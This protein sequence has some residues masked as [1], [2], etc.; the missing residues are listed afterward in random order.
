MLNEAE[1]FKTEKNKNAVLNLLI[2]EFE[3]PDFSKKEIQATFKSCLK[4]SPLYNRI[5]DK[6][7]HKLFPNLYRKTVELQ[8]CASNGEIIKKE[9]TLQVSEKSEEL[10]KLL[11]D[12]VAKFELFDFLLFEFRKNTDLELVIIKNSKTDIRLALKEKDKPF[13]YVQESSS[14]IDFNNYVFN[15]FV[16]F[17][18][19]MNIDQDLKYVYIDLLE[20]MFKR[21]NFLNY[22]Y[23]KNASVF[24]CKIED[25]Y[26]FYRNNKYYMFLNEDY[27]IEINIKEKSIKLKHSTEIED[28][29]IVEDPDKIF[30]FNKMGI[31]KNKQKSVVEKLKG[32][33]I[34][35]LNLNDVKNNNMLQF[36]Y[37]A[38]T[39]KQEYQLDGELKLITKLIG[40]LACP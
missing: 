31:D 25:L 14:D 11:K 28:V 34:G 39:G 27:A 2:A 7:K 26:S 23:I 29:F 8:L 22:K 19:S 4:G 3:E 6:V 30:I 12:A 18:D 35:N 24:E 5:F 13:I 37:S 16:D 10:K 20:K 33:D 32:I 1:F 36:F 38:I 9:F 15:R 21:K 17:I 40:I